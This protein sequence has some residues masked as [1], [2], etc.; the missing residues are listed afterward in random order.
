MLCT[1]GVHNKIILNIS[2][3][4]GLYNNI[5]YIVRLKFFITAMRCIST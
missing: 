5:L 3:Y 4:I 1:G 2:I